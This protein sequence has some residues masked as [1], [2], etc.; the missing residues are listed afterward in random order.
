MYKIE[1]WNKNEDVLREDELT[2]NSVESWNSVGKVTLPMKPSIW[3][4][5]EAFKKGN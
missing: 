1:D 3:V 5:M 2:T 4:V